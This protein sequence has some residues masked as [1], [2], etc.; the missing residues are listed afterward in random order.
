MVNKMKIY[1][2]CD[3]RGVEYQNKIKTYLEKKGYEVE[4]STVQHNDKDDYPD[5]AFDVCEK[6]VKTPN[7]FGILLCG[8]GIGMSIAANKVK[9]IRAARCVSKSDAYYSKIHNDANV[10]CLVINDTPVE[11][12]IEIVDEFLNNTSPTEERH[13]N[14]VNKIIHYEQ[15]A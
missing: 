11:A 6:V 7:S 8:T 9:G 14:R 10:L 3:H 13:Q 12:L 5:F 2:G 15:G 4:K 1:I